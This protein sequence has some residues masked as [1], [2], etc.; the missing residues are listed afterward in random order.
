VVTSAPR[1]LKLAL[2][3]FWFSFD[4][5]ED[6]VLGSVWGMLY[7]QNLN[8]MVMGCGVGSQGGCGVGSQGFVRALRVCL[9]DCCAALAM[10]G[11][12]LLSVVWLLDCRD[13]FVM[14][15][16]HHISSKPKRLAW[17]R[18]CSSVSISSWEKDPG[19]IYGAIA[20]RCVY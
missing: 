11:G 13:G 6:T 4:D 14:L 8:V 19:S 10:T 16:G 20:C 7:V 9:L 3:D 1:P 12:S 18:T 17:R 15:G 2:A 5:L